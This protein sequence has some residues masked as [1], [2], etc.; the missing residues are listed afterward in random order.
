MSG[1][2]LRSALGQ[3]LVTLLQSALKAAQ[4][5]ALLSGRDWLHS[6]RH[7]LRM[8]GGCALLSGR[9]WLHFQ[10]S[11]LFFRCVALCSRA[12]I[13]YTAVC[14]PRPQAGVALCSRA[15]SGYTTTRHRLQPARVALCSRAGIG[16][17]RVART[18]FRDRSCD[19][20][21]TRKV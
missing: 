9:D 13:G 21:R 19:L 5:C 15:G 18:S 1:K 3:G 4:S 8:H 2:P 20:S 12:G 10:C 16:Y 17:T 7:A 11:G 14:T 6:Q